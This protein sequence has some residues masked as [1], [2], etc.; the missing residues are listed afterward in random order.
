MVSWQILP[1]SHRLLI[2]LGIAYFI[3]IATRGV[4]TQLFA[5][6]P[7]TVSSGQYWRFATY[8]LASSSF[9][10]MLA[11]SL[12][13]YFFAPEVER[14]VSPRRLLLLSAIF[15]IVHALVY[16]PALWIAGAPL[17]GTM[18]LALFVLTIYVYLYPTGEVSLFGILPLR[19]T[20]LL[21]L[22]FVVTVAGSIITLSF[23]PTALINA[24]ADVGFGIFFGFVFS[25]LY[26]GHFSSSERYSSHSDASSHTRQSVRQTATSPSHAS[27]GRYISNEG[28]RR[29][30]THPDHHADTESDP[31]PLDEEH[32][33]E[34]LDKINEHGQSSLTPQERK[35]LQDY[36]NKL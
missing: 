30:G 26:F 21:G 15:I 32:L 29:L 13:L 25:H 3:N 7:T 24:F 12:I 35:F 9:L 34:I 31:I 1:T 33:N 14:I 36:A 23:N 20:M 27:V 11:S 8:P 28:E 16:M 18:S 5:L 19:A 6:I 17:T 10:E 4:L 2:V 22:I